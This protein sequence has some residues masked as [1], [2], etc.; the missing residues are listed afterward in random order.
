MA[1]YNG[2]SSKVSLTL[3]IGGAALSLSHVG[4]NSIVVQDDCQ[5]L[6]AGDAE[7]VIKVDRSE[8]K[9][10]VFLPHGVPGPRQVVQFI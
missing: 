8:D 4:P 2:Y 7:I 1:S 3:L 10:K 9:Y 5:P 6:P